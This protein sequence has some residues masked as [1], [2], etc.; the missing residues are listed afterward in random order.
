[1]VDWMIVITKSKTDRILL[2]CN[3]LEEALLGYNILRKRLTAGYV[4]VVAKYW[5]TEPAVVFADSREEQPGEVTVT[6]AQPAELLSDMVEFA[7]KVSE[8]DPVW[9]GQKI[10]GQATRPDPVKL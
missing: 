4:E 8:K 10:T 1:M 6:Y 7:K 3:S 5:A 2:S 9:D